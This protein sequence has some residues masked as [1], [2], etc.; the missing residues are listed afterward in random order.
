[1]IEIHTNIKVA[2]SRYNC[3]KLLGYDVILDAALMPHLLE[4]NTRPSM[5]PEKVDCAVNQP[6]VCRGWN[7]TME[8]FLD[9]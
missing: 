6:M 9:I 3:Y 1:M 2:H 5:Y 4:I 7:K 8:P